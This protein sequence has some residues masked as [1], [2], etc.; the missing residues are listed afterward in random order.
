[1]TFAIGHVEG[2]TNA[3]CK[4]P[5]KQAGKQWSCACDRI[6]P[7]YMVACTVCKER[8]PR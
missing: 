2:G 7:R 8:Q 4:R 6:Q 3:G 5:L 1:V